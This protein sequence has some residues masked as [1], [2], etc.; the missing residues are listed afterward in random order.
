MEKYTLTTNKS[1]MFADLPDIFAVSDLQQALGI[2]R[3]TAYRLIDE[4][5]I[6]HIRIGRKIRIPKT[7]LVEFVMKPQQ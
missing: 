7:Y 6:Q 5:Q 1:E 3:N 2:G 4:K